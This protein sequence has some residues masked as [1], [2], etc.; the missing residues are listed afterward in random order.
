MALPQVSS[1]VLLDSQI[2]IGP[3]DSSGPLAAALPP[4]PTPVAVRLIPTTATAAFVDRFMV[5]SW[6]KPTRRATRIGGLMATNSRRRVGSVGARRSAGAPHTA[7][8]GG[9]EH[10]GAS[11]VADSPADCL[12]IQQAHILPTTMCPPSPHNLARSNIEVV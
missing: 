12:A 1:A 6:L 4:S 2:C 10:R 3:R 7:G 8:T 9:G 5:S 11:S